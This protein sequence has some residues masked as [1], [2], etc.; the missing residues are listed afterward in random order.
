[1]INVADLPRF[2]ATSPPARYY[3]FVASI[4]A[5]ASTAR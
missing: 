2:A 5:L 3:V 1:M 4:M